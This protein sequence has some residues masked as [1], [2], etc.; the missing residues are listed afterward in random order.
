MGQKK[1]RN[2]T[3]VGFFLFVGLVCL[4]LMIAQFSNISSKFNGDYK[5]NVSF[6][7]ASGLVKDSDVTF[8]G[9][10]VGRVVSKPQMQEDGSIMV[11]LSIKGQV[12]IPK[13]ASFS[14]FSVSLLGDKAVA[15]KNP[16]EKS[17]VYYQNG[18]LVQGAAGGGIDEIASEAQDIVKSANAAISDIRKMA[19]RVET[20][21]EGF[22]TMILELNS[23]L[24]SIN[25][26]ILTKDNTSSIK[27]T[28][29]NLQKSSETL[30]ETSAKL[31]PILEKA[32]PL[33][34]EA[35]DTVAVV[36]KATQTA[37]KTFADASEQIK[38]L[39]PALADLPETLKNLRVASQKATVMMDKVGGIADD[40]KQVVASVKNGNGLIKTLT[41]DQKLKEDTKTFVKNLKEY[42]ILRYR[43][44][45]A[46]DKEDPKRSRFRG[47]RR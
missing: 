2:A 20:S 38:N 24:K 23:A 35:K 26:S 43:D 10:K 32:D 28:L 31:K 3:I 25:T 16:K 29:A 5:L 17:G 41:D 7:D 12:K 27:V 8:G 40:T 36:K 18:D 13:G 22:D 44:D 19:G 11:T 39:E 9:A 34:A 6:P 14:I 21:I 42:G 47:E 4:G 15:I 33:F 45:E 46:E 30:K 1:D 37:E